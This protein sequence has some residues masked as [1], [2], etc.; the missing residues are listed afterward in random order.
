MQSRRERTRRPL[1]PS[2]IEATSSGVRPGNALRTRLRGCGKGS[3]ILARVDHAEMARGQR[4]RLIGEAVELEKRTEAA[5][6]EQLEDVV[7]ELAGPGIDEAA[8]AH[9]TP[10]DAD[11]V[12]SVLAGQ[13]PGEEIPHEELAE[14]WL[15]DTSDPEDESRE[16]LAEITRLEEEIARSRGRRDAFERY[17]DALDG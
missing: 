7:A 1:P 13:M 2:R 3:I 9:M 15:A 12:R 6:Q 4:R 14:D 16:L 17:V 11:L 8:F 10:E 5:L